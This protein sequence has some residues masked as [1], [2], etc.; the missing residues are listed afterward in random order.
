MTAMLADQYFLA[1]NADWAVLSCKQCWLSSM[2]LQ[3]MLA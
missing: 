3:T 2:F 1:N